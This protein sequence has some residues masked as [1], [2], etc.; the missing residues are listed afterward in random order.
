MLAH[1]GST[2]RSAGMTGSLGSPAGPGAGAA[3]VGVLPPGLTGAAGGAGGAGFAV[4]GWSWAAGAVAGGPAAPGGCGVRAIRITAGRTVTN[5]PNPRLTRLPYTDSSA[6]GTTPADA[7]TPTPGFQ[8]VPDVQITRVSTLQLAQREDLV[9]GHIQVVRAFADDLE[10]SIPGIPVVKREI[11]FKQQGVR[12]V[13]GFTVSSPRRR[14]CPNPAFA[15]RA[16]EC[17]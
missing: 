15:D 9:S 16:M 12:G 8:P 14:T 2:T 11:R 4:A 17:G 7:L 10:S 6:L 13:I 5:T 1:A 3:P